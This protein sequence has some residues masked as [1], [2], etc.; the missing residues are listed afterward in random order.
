M[1]TSEAQVLIRSMVKEGKLAY[2]K[3]KGLTLTDKATGVSLETLCE[4]S[5]EQVSRIGQEFDPLFPTRKRLKSLTNSGV[6]VDALRAMLDELEGK[7]PTPEPTNTEGS[8]ENAED[9]QGQLLLPG[10]ETEPGTGGSVPIEGHT[11]AED[12]TLS[13]SNGTSDNIREG[14]NG[15]DKPGTPGRSGKRGNGGTV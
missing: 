11:A 8:G 1:K 13:G 12:E 3:E 14:V 6:S 9:N 10:D 7:K 4:L 15:G 5:T 2:C